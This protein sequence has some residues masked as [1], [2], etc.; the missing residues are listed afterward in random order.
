MS[1]AESK[2]HQFLIKF[3]KDFTNKEFLEYRKERNWS[4]YDESTSIDKLMMIIREVKEYK[5]GYFEDEKE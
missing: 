3:T 2:L 1:P 4:K 5:N